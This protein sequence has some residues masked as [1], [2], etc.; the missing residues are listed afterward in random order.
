MNRKTTLVDL[1]PTSH[2][3]QIHLRRCHF[4]VRQG[5]SLI[6]NPIDANPADFGWFMEEGYYKPIKNLMQLPNYF[7]VRCGCTARCTGRCK[8]NRS[9]T[10]CTE[11]CKC[12]VSRENS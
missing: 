3:I 10:V 7:Y 9:E 8:C 5:I 11:Y 4:V 12:K 1:P 6:E 2:S